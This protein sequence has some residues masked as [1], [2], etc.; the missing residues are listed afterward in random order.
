MKNKLFIVLCLGITLFGILGFGN[1]TL[2]SKQV[3]STY[4]IPDTMD[5]KEIMKTVEMAYDIEA[6]SAYTFDLRKFPNVFINDP[7]FPVDP[8]TLEVVRELTN[9]PSLESAGWLDYK[10]AYYS[11]RM[12]ATL[13]AEAIKEKA[14]ADNRELTD[15]EKKSLIDS[16]GRSA[17]ARAEDPYRHQPLLFMSVNIVD[18]IATVVL[19]DGPTTIELTVVLVDKQWYIAGIKG[20]SIHP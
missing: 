2:V 1:T 16:N 18:D 19:N 12:D 3:P 20:I 11:W 10:L 17:P 4:S 7:R 14:K 9:N 13:Y 5:A 8:S 6:E 15:S